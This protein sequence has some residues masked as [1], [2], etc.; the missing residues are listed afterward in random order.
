MREGP[1]EKPSGMQTE[2][3]PGRTRRLTQDAAVRDPRGLAAQGSAASWL[4]CAGLQAS[5]PA[6][7]SLS[8]TRPRH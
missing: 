4:V 1:G 3:V 2:G 5:R 7:G 8:W 6:D